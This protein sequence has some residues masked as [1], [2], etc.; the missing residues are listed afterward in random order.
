M[1]LSHS[2][3]FDQVSFSE[4]LKQIKKKNKP[5]FATNVKNIASTY[6]NMSNT[7]H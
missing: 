4:A 1:Y 6:F 7:Y 3:N 2:L 5:P